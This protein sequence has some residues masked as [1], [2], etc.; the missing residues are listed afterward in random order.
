MGQ[1]GKQRRGC[2]GWGRRWGVVLNEEGLSVQ[3]DEKV[4]EVENGDGCTTV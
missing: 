1:D 3:E 2:W 4:L